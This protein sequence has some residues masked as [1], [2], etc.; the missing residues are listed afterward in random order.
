M[1]FYGFMV[2]AFAVECDAAGG[3]FLVLCNYISHKSMLH[4]FSVGFVGYFYV[5]FRLW[6]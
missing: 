5:E 2:Y 6:L 3:A 4:G 1:G